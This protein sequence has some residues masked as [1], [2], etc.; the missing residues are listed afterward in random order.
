M[1]KQRNKLHILGVL[2]AGLG[3]QS[4]GETPSETKTSFEPGTTLDLE[5]NPHS[6]DLLS[7]V[8]QPDSPESLKFGVECE[9]ESEI[10]DI[11]L[12]YEILK[13][14]SAVVCIW[15]DFERSREVQTSWTLD[16][17]KISLP[18]G[19]QIKYRWIVENVDGE[20]LRTKW[21]EFTFNDSR[22]EWQEV[23]GDK[24]SILWYQGARDFAESLLNASE[25]A[26]DRLARG[27]GAHLEKEAKVYIYANSN[28]LRNAMVF[29]QEWTGGVAFTD[30]GTIAIGISPSNLSWGMRALAHELT[31]LVIHQMTSGPFGELPTWL[32]EGLA[33]YAEGELRGDFRSALE[34]AISGKSLI[35]LQSLSGSFP[36]DPQ[37]AILAYAQSY[38][39]VNFLIQ[40][41]GSE[42][43]SRLL[44]EFKEGS[45]PDEALREV[46]GFG[47]EGL[48]RRW[49]ASLGLGASVGVIPGA[50][51]S[52]PRS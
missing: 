39:I 5:S 37:E 44:Q 2:V 21:G 26:L 34:Q 10:V 38:S 1:G 13:R 33:V 29:P 25:E 23:S 15:P 19:A 43:I 11:E 17:R 51:N 35:S 42:R 3:C 52:L 6:I 36:A 8:V 20:V 18:P 28:D 49:K 50:W 41:Y 32:D 30:Y 40:E 4:G 47:T 12:H 24:I 48:E 46:Y 14:N 16:T 9:G 22:Y 45:T 27:V 31:H 7:T